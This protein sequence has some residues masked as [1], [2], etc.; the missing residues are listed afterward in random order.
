MTILATRAFRLTACGAIAFAFVAFVARAAYQVFFKARD[1]HF[2][3]IP[4][5]PE[6]HA[7]A[8]A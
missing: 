8:P 2:S 5:A 4:S 6:H 7:I 1:T 3:A